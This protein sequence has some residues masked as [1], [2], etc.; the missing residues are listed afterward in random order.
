MINISEDIYERLRKRLNNYV[1][2]VPTHEKLTAFLKECFNEEEA[3]LVINFKAPFLDSLSASQ[4]SKR[5]GMSEEKVK[6]IMERLAK[7]GTILREEIGKKKRIRYS[8]LPFFPGL[9]EFFFL[10]HKNHT[11]EQN[12][13]AAQLYSEYYK[14]GYHTEIGKS[15]FSFWRV[16][17]SSKPVEN[18][19]KEIEINQNIEIKHQILPFEVVSEFITQSPTIAIAT[20]QCRLHQDIIKEKKCKADIEETCLC[21]GMAANFVTGQKFGRIID[22]EEAMEIIRKC[23]KQG[24]VH[25]VM[26]VEKGAENMFICNCCPDC[27]VVLRE[28]AQYKNKLTYAVSNFTPIFDQE[29]C[30][31]CGTCVKICPVNAFQQK[32]E[33]SEIIF[34]GEECLGCGL[35]ASNCPSEAIKL[36]KVRDDMPASN[37][38]E[39]FVKVENTRVKQP[40][41]IIKKTD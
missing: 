11:P 40:E 38:G 17:P 30:K 4:L 35:C 29:K 23:E 18:R 28:I 31:R 37:A 34:L 10:A 36:I 22:K 9:Y 24:L 1:L 33:K 8:L 25:T 26:N 3:G 41:I 7:R 5:S 21:L 39:L 16:L 27:C 14:S 2:K 6:E 12:L 20:C 32:T 13:R 19:K 15:K